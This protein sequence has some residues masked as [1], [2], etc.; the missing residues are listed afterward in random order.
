MLM[1]LSMTASG[2]MIGSM[3][4]VR[5]LGMMA[6]IILVISIVVRSMAKASTPG[7]MVHHMTENGLIM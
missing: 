3:V 4:M 2:R 6:Q 7:K 1:A 5:R